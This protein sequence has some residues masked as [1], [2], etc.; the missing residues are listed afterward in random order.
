MADT[1][2]SEIIRETSDMVLF[3]FTNSSDG[4]GRSDLQ[5]LDASDLTYKQVTVTLDGVPCLLYTS[6]AADE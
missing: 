4:T 2:T 3:T 1:V 5:V 6:D